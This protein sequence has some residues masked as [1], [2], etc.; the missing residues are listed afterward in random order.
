MKGFFRRELEREGSYWKSGK[1]RGLRAK[2]PFLLPPR[3]G[4]QR[5]GR[6]GTGGALPAILGRGGGRKVGEKREGGP[7]ESIPPLTSGGGGLWRRR[8]GG[9][10]RRPWW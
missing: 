9:G 10:R 1:G 3:D 2:S 7:G 4:K 6:G 8:D 5:M